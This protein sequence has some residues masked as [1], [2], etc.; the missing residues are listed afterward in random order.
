MS[1]SLDVIRE[2]DTLIVHATDA[3]RA[4]EERAAAAVS[5]CERI[6]AADVKLIRAFDWIELRRWAAE[7]AQALALSAGSN[8]GRSI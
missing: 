5:A 4:P 1:H 8:R 7:R 3:A 6:R 2:I